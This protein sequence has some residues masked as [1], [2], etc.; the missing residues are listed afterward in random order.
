MLVRAGMIAVLLATSAAH[1]AE[2]TPELWVDEKTL[3]IRTTA[4]GADAHWSPVWVAVIDEAVYVRLGR[5]AAGRIERNTTAP[6]VAV[7]IAGH[8]FD[9][10]RAEPAPDMAARV[11]REMKEK[12]WTDVFIRFFPHPMTLQ[13]VPEPA[14]E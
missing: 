14:E 5:R 4:P 11:A 2:W 13:L 10:V 12:Y 1:A 3:D 7:R 6:Y 9:R 8:E